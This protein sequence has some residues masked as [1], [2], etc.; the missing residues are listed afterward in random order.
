MKAEARAQLGVFFSYASEDGDIVSQFYRAFQ[1]LNETVGQNLRI[2]FDRYEIRPGD[3]IA[4][5]IRNALR[6]SEYLVIFYTGRMKKS[7]S[8]TGVELGYFEGLIEESGPDSKRRVVSIFLD[9]PPGTTADTQG[10]HVHVTPAELNLSREEYMASM[11]A[12]KRFADHALT[13]FLKEIARKA[14]KLMPADGLPPDRLEE[15]LFARNRKIETEIVP[16]IWMAM[17]SCLGSRVA[18]RSIEQKL[19]EI[20]IDRYDPETAGAQIPPDARLIEHGDTLGIFGI[21]RTAQAPT[22]A[23]FRREVEQRYPANAPGIFRAIDR[24]FASA[25]GAMPI[26][27]DQLIRSPVDDR[28]YRVIIT[29]HFD[30]YNRKKIIHLYFIEKRRV[31]EFGDPATSILL[32]FVNVS[33]RYRFMFLERT[34]ELSAQAF[35]AQQNPVRVR[36]NV[37]RLMQELLFI[38][39]ESALL[40]LSGAQAIAA[41]FGAGED[42]EEIGMIAK[43]WDESRSTLKA[44]AD[45]LLKASTEPAEF[46]QVR[47][48]WLQALRE[49]TKFAE[50]VNVMVGLRALEKL[51]AFYEPSVPVRTAAVAAPTV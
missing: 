14:T 27:N 26:D 41:L 17:H 33:A 29:R 5:D 36:A 3:S 45:T 39:D 43:E 10:I 15:A 50:R 48:Q 35:A 2:F 24:V 22:W 16:S 32:A 9:Q 28:T 49:F 37:H 23:E 34:S 44:A 30:Y 51:K 12:E 47:A 20:E 21:E 38:E 42:Y 40:K 13:S 11:Q 4:E 25:L 6:A 8:W 19:V 46:S 31:D 1:A 18:R 7:H